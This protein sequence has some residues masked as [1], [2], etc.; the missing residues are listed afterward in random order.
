[1]NFI[2]ATIGGERKI[3]TKL[4]FFKYGFYRE[5]ELINKSV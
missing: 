2:E 1:M 3:S 4:A 5:Y